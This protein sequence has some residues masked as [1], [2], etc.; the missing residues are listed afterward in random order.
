MTERVSSAGLAAVVRRTLRRRSE[1]RSRERDRGPR[2]PLADEPLEIDRR[3]DGL[4][5][6]RLDHLA[7]HDLAQRGQIAVHARDEGAVLAHLH[8]VAQLVQRDGRS[9]LLRAGHLAEVGLSPDGLRDPVR[10]HAILGNERRA[11]ADAREDALQQRCP[12]LEEVDEVDPV[13]A[14]S[15]LRLLHGDERRDRMSLVRQQQVVAGGR[16]PEHAEGDHGEQ[17][18]RE[19]QLSGAEEPAH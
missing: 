8:V 10:V 16:E 17:A 5:V 7:G 1:P 4:A 18:A 14:P 15:A 12:P 11:V 2:R 19:E 9:D 3:A 6:D 13:L